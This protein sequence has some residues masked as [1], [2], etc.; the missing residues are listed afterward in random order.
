MHNPNV[1]LCNPST[2][3]K[4]YVIISMG[5]IS[6]SSFILLP[7]IVKVIKSFDLDPWWN[8]IEPIL[9]HVQFQMS[10][11]FTLQSL[12]W[13][14]AI[15]FRVF[16]TTQARLW[17]ICMRSS[18][19]KGWATNTPFILILLSSIEIWLANPSSLNLFWLKHDVPLQNPL[20]A[21]NPE[22]N[23]IFFF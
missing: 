22:I 12:S 17:L 8:V 21:Q 1:K 14:L 11:G 3:T 7:H 19:I 6:V 18:I 4:Q 9:L 5:S 2:S 13:S 16:I 20:P 15:G 10:D 23:E